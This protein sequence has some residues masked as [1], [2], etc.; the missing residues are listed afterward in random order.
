MCYSRQGKQRVLTGPTLC[1]A[2][3]PALTLVFPFLPQGTVFDYYVDDQ[4][5]CMAHWSQ[6]VPQFTY[7]PGENDWR[8]P[9][10]RWSGGRPRSLPVLQ[11]WPPT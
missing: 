8:C 5:V 6:R 3:R 10:V 7:I 11:G 1:T 2:A 4:N 9:P